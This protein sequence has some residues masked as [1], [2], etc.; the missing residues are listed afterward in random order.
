[1]NHHRGS[2][3]NPRA[4][5]MIFVGYSI[6]YRTIARYQESRG[7]NEI[8]EE[9]TESDEGDDMAGDAEEAR[10]ETTSEQPEEV[11]TEMKRMGGIPRRDSWGTMGKEI[12]CLLKNET[13]R[14][15]KRPENKHVIG[16]RFIFTN[17][18]NDEGI[19]KKKT[20][21][22][23]IF[24][25]AAC[26]SHVLGVRKQPTVA[27]SSTEGECMAMVEASKESRYLQRIISEIGC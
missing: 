22:L 1:M 27:L 21:I 24:V 20:F 14:I 6:E 11:R 18:V 12:R 23:R 4:R 19:E 10:N 17:N 13:F 7:V 2:N 16:N 8:L 15:I 9:F 3:I 26:K 5:K 25:R